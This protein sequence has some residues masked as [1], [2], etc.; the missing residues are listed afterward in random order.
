M[1]R[2]I[3]LSKFRG[4]SDSDEDAL[5]PPKVHDAKYLKPADEISGLTSGC[6]V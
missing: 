5:P 3:D 1:P 6:L 2:G 4:D